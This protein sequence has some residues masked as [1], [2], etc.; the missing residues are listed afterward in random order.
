MELVERYLLKSK[1]SETSFA[2]RPQVLR[3]PVCLPL[4]RTGSDKSAFCRDDE[5]FG[6]RHQRF[7]NE[8]LG[9]KR[10][11][12][13]RGIDQVDSE[14]DCPTEDGDGSCVIGRRSPHP[15]TGDSHRSKTKSVDDEI[16]ADLEDSHVAGSSRAKFNH[17]L[18]PWWSFE[19]QARC[20]QSS[21]S[22]TERQREQ[23]NLR[24]RPEGRSR[25]N[26]ASRVRA[27]WQRRQML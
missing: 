27:R 12:R 7:R 3:A 8:L 19:K 20:P 18:T 25:S 23:Q 1:A 9:H 5:I 2:G 4:A 17:R 26:V 16:V 15:V 14:V 24:T 6:V 21:S 22:V 13:V 11:V 10:S